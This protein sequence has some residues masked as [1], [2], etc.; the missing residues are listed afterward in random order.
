M[1]LTYVFHSGFVLETGK[2]IL[3]FDY[4]MDLAGVVPPG[5]SE[6]ATL[7]VAVS[8]LSDLKLGY[9]FLCILWPAASILLGASRNMQIRRI[10]ISGK[11]VGK[12]KA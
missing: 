9:S 11:S 12:E 6:T 7:L 5:A 8:S 1:T 3:I 10:S 2:S 4:W